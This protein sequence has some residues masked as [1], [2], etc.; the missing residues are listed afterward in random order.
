LV[1]S[2]RQQPEVLVQNTETNPQRLVQK[3]IATAKTTHAGA[4]GGHGWPCL[5]FVNGY[6]AID[7]AG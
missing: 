7:I 6:Y 4:A 5:R 3:T 1:A 2:R